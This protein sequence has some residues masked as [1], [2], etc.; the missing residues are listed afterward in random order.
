MKE[1]DFN[2]ELTKRRERLIQTGYD[3]YCLF[4]L[5]GDEVKLA[6]E[7]NRFYEDCLALPFMRMVHKSRDGE[8]FMEQDAILKGYVFLYIPCGIEIASIKIVNCAFRILKHD[9]EKTALSE[10]DRH[11]AEWILSLGGLIGLSKALRIGEHVKIIEGPLLDVEGSIVKYSKKNRNCR[12]EINIVGQQL[13][14][15]L[16]FD[17]V[18][19]T[20][21]AGGVY[22]GDKEQDDNDDH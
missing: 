5:S 15:W 11:Y 2:E 13:S 20:G 18:R 21:A 14:V 4:G 3:V 22:D 17:W 6:N 19:S 9:G 8:K 1:W 12:V 7:L 16:P 10:M